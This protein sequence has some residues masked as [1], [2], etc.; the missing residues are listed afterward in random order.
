MKSLSECRVQCLNMKLHQIRNAKLPKIVKIGCCKP[1]LWRRS[2]HFFIVVKHVHTDT[3]THTHV[4]VRNYICIYETRGRE[5]GTK[6]GRAANV[7]AKAKTKKQ[8]NENKNENRASLLHPCVFMWKILVF[9][10]VLCRFS[11]CF[12]AKWA[13]SVVDYWHYLYLWAEWQLQPPNL[14]LNLDI[15]STKGN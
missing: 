7:K 8:V 15:C 6:R 12:S 5:S 11:C 3:R 4:H 9:S 2:R 1:D 14:R 10:C 13:P